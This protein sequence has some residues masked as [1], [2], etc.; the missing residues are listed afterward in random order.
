MVAA[1]HTVRA[2][3]ELIAGQAAFSAGQFDE[4]LKHFDASVD[5]APTSGEPHLWR[6]KCL[7]S[8][9]RSKEA[10]GEYRMALLLSTDKAVTD[11]CKTQLKQLNQAIPQGNVEKALKTPTKFTLETRKLDWR[12]DTGTSAHLLK[13]LQG[14]DNELGALIHGRQLNGG[15]FE[16]PGADLELELKNGPPHAMGITGEDR[17]LLAN[18][19]VMIILDRSGSMGQND[20][21]ATEPSGGASS[22]GESRLLWSVEELTLFSRQICAIM[23]HGFTFITFDFRPT[24]FDIRTAM[25]FNQVLNTLQSGG[26]TALTPALEQAYARH[27]LHPDQPLLIAVVSDCQVDL[28]ESLASMVAATRRYPLPKGVFFSLMQI[29]ITAE[30]A[31]ATHQAFPSPKIAKADTLYRLAHLRELGAAYD[32]SR[33]IPFSQLRKEGLGHCILS[34]LRERVPTTK[35]PNVRQGVGSKTK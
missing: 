30:A 35:V 1:P 13:T 15:A 2:E 6:A 32:A 5:A 18:A 4:A 9:G 20:C 7:A 16:A 24:V 26:G 33:L 12:L 22:H 23:P 21:P 31:N 27:A 3:D 10:G 34:L 14:Q 29:G 17:A 19:D 28:E 25:Q 11:E 8:M